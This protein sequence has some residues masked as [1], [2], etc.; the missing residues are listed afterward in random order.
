MKSDYFTSG[1]FAGTVSKTLYGK[2]RYLAERKAVKI[3][4]LIELLVNTDYFTSNL[5]GKT[6]SQEN[7]NLDS[8]GQNMKE[9]PWAGSSAG[10]QQTNV[11][12]RTSD[13][14]S[15]SPGFKS[16]PVHQTA[17]SVQLA[18]FRQ[19]FVASEPPQSSKREK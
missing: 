6:Q 13:L 2:L 15:E 8:N 11:G 19:P 17:F 10:I 16:P 14:H 12:R 18:L 4:K 9:T 3:P 1:S 5:T 7:L